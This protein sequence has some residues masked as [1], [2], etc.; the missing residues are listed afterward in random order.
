MEITARLIEVLPVQTGP[1]RNGGEWKRQDFVVETNDQYPKKICFT[2]WG[3]KVDASVLQVGNILTVSFDVESR[4]YQG[5][6]YTS[7]TAWRV[8]ATGEGAPAAMP[9]TVIPPFEPLPADEKDDLPF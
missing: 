8:I 5:R 7:A 1:S 9:D 2:V 4:E 6:W 3:D